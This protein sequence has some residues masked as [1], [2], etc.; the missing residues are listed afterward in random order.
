MRV[1]LARMVELNLH[2]FGVFS[3]ALTR[4]FS[5]YILYFSAFRFLVVFF[6]IGK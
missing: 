2:S 6:F 1:I 3:V 4:F 5:V